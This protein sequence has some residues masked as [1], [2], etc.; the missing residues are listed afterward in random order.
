MYAIETRNSCLADALRSLH[1]RG[2]HA[3]FNDLVRY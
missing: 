1:I 3:F 2:N